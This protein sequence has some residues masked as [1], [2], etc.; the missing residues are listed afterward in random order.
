MAKKNVKRV[1]VISV[2]S[3]A[4]LIGVIWGLIWGIIAFILTGFVGV[5]LQGPGFQMGVGPMQG[6]GAGLGILALLMGLLAGAV[7]GFIGGAIS[8]LLYN[9]ASKFTGGFELDLEEP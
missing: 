6:M 9:A 7:G 1:G 3:T 2:A 8:A 4:A 5:P